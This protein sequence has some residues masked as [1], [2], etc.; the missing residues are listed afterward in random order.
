MLRVLKILNPN[1]CN[2][3]FETD[4]LRVKRPHT[5]ISSKYYQ[6]GLVESGG[7]E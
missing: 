6:L 1:V 4:L 2:V 7:M 5:I 3:F